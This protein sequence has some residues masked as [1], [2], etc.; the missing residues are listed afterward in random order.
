MEKGMKKIVIFLLIVV[1]VF[2]ALQSAIAGGESEPT[3][4]LDKPVTLTMWFL[5]WKAGLMAVDSGFDLFQETYPNITLEVTPVPQAN[6][7]EKW[8]P[9]YQAGNEPDVCVQPNHLFRSV[10]PAAVLMKLDPDVFT[11]EEYDNLFYKSMGTPIVGSDG[12][13]YGVPGPDPVDGTGIGVNIDILS[14]AGIDYTTL[15]TWDKIIE[16]A[17]K[18][19][20]WEDGKMVRAGL[21]M[22]HVIAD[23]NYFTSGILELGGSYYDEATHTFDF[24]TP[25]AV[26]AMTFLVDLI[27][28]HKVSDPEWNPNFFNGSAAMM[29]NGPAHYTAAKM[30]FNQNATYIKRPPIP[31]AVNSWTYT[32]IGPNFYV[33]SNRLEDDELKYP[34]AIAYA[35]FLSS[36]EWSK[37]VGEGYF[38]FQANRE[39]MESDYVTFELTKPLKPIVEAM[40]EGKFVYIPHYISATTLFMGIFNRHYDEA[41]RGELTIE[42]ALEKIENEAN[43]A[44]EEAYQTYLSTKVN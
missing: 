39:F 3:V 15:D 41:I 43:I 25:E 7:I 42:E 8:L 29:T 13:V 35:K 31:G 16:A 37:I 1:F 44:E 40:E 18:V 14:E 19:T 24:T 34:A 23:G 12:H 36:K 20:L 30:V 9:A 11:K 5:D 32:D 6:L 10:D 26:Q 4:D 2:G 33:F 17:Q 22:K 27:K 28:V 38:A 21:Q